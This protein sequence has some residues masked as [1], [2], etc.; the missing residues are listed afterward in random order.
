M[1]KFFELSL[2]E[3]S[4]SMADVCT[5]VTLADVGTYVTLADDDVGTYVT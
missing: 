1:I 4:L 2:L 3:F 5:Y